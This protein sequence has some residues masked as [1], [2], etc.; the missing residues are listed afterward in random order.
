MTDLDDSVDIEKVS[1]V[2]NL[3]VALSKNMTIVSEKQSKK[4]MSGQI[5]ARKKS[6]LAQAPTAT[7]ALFSPRQGGLKSYNEDELAQAQ[8]I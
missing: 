7:L 4:R 5:G 2:D 6:V 1:E 8:R 3:A